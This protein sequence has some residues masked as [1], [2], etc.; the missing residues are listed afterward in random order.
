[1]NRSVSF[2]IV[3]AILVTIL[4]FI[5]FSNGFAP[6]DKTKVITLREAVLLSE[7]DRINIFISELLDARSASC[8]KKV[9]MAESHMNPK[10]KNPNSSAKGIGQLLDET[11]KNI[12]LRHS[13]DPL[14][15]VIATIA[16]VSRHYGSS[17]MCSAWASEQKLHYF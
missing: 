9:L 4:S 6:R 12:G 5:T 2:V 8:L 17:G 16:Y 7:K 13:A 11:Y 3:S 10:A 1:M 14:A 15:Q